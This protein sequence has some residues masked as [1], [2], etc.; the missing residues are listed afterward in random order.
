MQLAK[1]NPFR[2]LQRMQRDMDKFWD[3]GW[4]LPAIADTSTLDMYEEDGKLVAEVCLPN[5]KKEEVSVKTEEGL[6][7]VV[8]EH[9]EEEEK[10]S[11]RRYYFRESNNRYFRRVNLPENAVVDGAEASFDNGVLKVTMPVTEPKKSKEIEVE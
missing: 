11:K 3:G 2:E 9:K 1:Y 8:A 6:L 4:D 5:F 7:E 10:E